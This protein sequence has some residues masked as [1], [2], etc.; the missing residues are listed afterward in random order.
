MLSSWVELGSY[1]GKSNMLEH[2][3]VISEEKMSGKFN[4]RTAS[5]LLPSLDGS[6]ESVKQLVDAIELY[7][8]LLD[9]DGK[10]LLIKYI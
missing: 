2:I 1:G 5:S 8:K 10:S 4:L 9:A 7:D 6:E 3:F